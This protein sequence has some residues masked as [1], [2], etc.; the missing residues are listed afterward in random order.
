MIKEPHAEETVMGGKKKQKTS[1]SSVPIRLKV[2][3]GWLR[4]GSVDLLS[5]FIQII[6]H[7]IMSATEHTDRG[8]DKASQEHE[9]EISAAL[10]G[11]KKE[12]ERNL[13][14]IQNETIDH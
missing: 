8:Q 13:P 7:E 9:P 11:E 5:Q 12:E 10:E 1:R 6:Y 4:Q 3:T 14:T 2:I